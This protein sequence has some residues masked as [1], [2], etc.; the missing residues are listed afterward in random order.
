MVLYENELGCLE[1]DAGPNG[2]F[3]FKISFKNKELRGNAS[4]ICEQLERML[5]AIDGI[6]EEIF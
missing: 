6:L 4:F 2:E 1:Y 5:K 3:W